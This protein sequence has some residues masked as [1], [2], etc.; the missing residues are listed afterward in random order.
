MVH[1]RSFGMTPS[2]EIFPDAFAGWLCGGVH[3]QHTW[4]CV[5]MS[6]SVCIG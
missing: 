4:V 3:G 6:V 1:V 2:K 5:I